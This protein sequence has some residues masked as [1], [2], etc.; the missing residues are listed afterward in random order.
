MPSFVF[1]NILA[2]FVLFFVLVKPLSLEYPR[3]IPLFLPHPAI[4]APAYDNVSTKGPP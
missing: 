4:L 3:T 2:S 1:N